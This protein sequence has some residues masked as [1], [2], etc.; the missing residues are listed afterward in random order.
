MGTKDLPA[1]IDYILKTTGKEKLTYFGHSQGT[2]QIFLGMSLNP[3]YFSSRV[4]GIIALGPVTR[5]ANVRSNFLY[6]LARSRL[7]EYL[8]WFG[9]YEMFSSNKPLN[10]IIA[11]IC[12]YLS[13]VCDSVLEMLSDS[14]PQDDD[15]VKF[16]VYMGHYP[17]GTSFKDLSHLAQNVRAKL[18]QQY[19]Y[20][21]ENWK[22][23][24][25]STPPEYNLRNIKN[26]VCLFIGTDDK[27]ATFKDNQWLI[28][29]LS[30]AGALKNYYILQNTGHLT[31]FLPKNFNYFENILKCLSD[32]ESNR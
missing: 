31:F 14:N 17:S 16:P 1:I 24:K 10:S 25:Q 15:P 5:L 28:S 29:E 4:K 20:G 22:Y 2:M 23:Y 6:L 12:N 3:D 32:F 30:A 26:K 18:F 21:K 19:D 11:K 7:D 27:M 8:G 13:I 9:I